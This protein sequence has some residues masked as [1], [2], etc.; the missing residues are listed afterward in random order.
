MNIK[1]TFRGMDSSPVIKEYVDN[2][3]EKVTRFLKR[4][5]TPIV[6]EIILEAART[7]HHHRTEIILKSPHYDLV[8]H[9]ECPE[10]YMSIDH[11]ID[12]MVHEVAR[13]KEKRIDFRKT[14]KTFKGS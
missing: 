2:H 6:I 8:S 14:A 3:I 1:V 11:A 12:K 4:E 13:A 7:H 9:H 5:T 10:M